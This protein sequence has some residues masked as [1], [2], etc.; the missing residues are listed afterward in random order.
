MA[1]PE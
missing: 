1:S